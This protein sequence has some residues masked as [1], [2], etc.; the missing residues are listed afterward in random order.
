[1]V[2]LSTTTPLLT[3][4]VELGVPLDG[5]VRVPTFAIIARTKVEISIV[6]CSFYLF[7]CAL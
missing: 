3:V 7:S 6:D 4:P 5:T 1:M 2:H